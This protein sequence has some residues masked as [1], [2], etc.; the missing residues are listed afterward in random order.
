MNIK[1]RILLFVLLLELSGYSI[2]LLTNKQYSEEALLSVREKQI[3]AIFYGNLYRINSLTGLME[4]NVSDLATTGEQYYKLQK[5][6]INEDYT[7]SI[8]DYLVNN[9]SRFPESIGGGLWYE[10]YKFKSD[11]LYYGPYAY[12]EGQEVVLTWD[13][14]T[15]EYD[16]HNQDWYL[17]ALPKGYDRKQ[18]PEKE[19]CWT[20]PYYDDA[21]TLMLMM[22]V[23]AFMYD[24]SNEIIGL[25]TVD[26]A[27]TE[28]TSFVEDIKITP[29][30]HS[31]L[32]D[33]QSEKFLSQT[34]DKSKVMRT[35]SED[36]WSK[37]IINLSEKGMINSHHA[38]IGNVNYVIY[39]IQTDVGM[40]FGEI[41]PE[42]DLLHEIQGYAERNFTIGIIISATFI[43]LMLIA[44]NILFR[45]FNSVLNLIKNSIVL[46]KENN[47]VN[48][49]PMN[50]EGDNEFYP[51]ILALNNVYKEINDYT[52]QIEQQNKILHDNKSEIETLNRELE[53]KVFERTQKLEQ[54]SKDLESSLEKLQ[55]AS[56]KLVETEKMA[57]LGQLV[58]GLAH[59]INTPIG[60]CV[61]VSSTLKNNTQDFKESLESGELLKSKLIKYSDNIIESTDLIYSNLNR[62]ADLINSFKS[63]A[64]DQTAD[65]HR[66]FDLKLYLEDIF[67]TLHPRIKNTE[68][69]V[70]QKIPAGLVIDSRPGAVSQLITN[71]FMNSLSHGFE[72]R[73]KGVIEIQV[74][75][76]DDDYLEIIFSDDGNGMS[77]E[78][79]NSVFEPFYTTKRN[80]GG[81]GLGLYIVYNLVTQVLGGT[82]DIDSKQG[83]GTTFIIKIPKKIQDSN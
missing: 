16:Y 30:S 78:I 6:S 53:R 67:K 2:L 50:Y 17:S 83:E 47:S 14:N 45:P 28:M 72:G 66:E 43:I 10:P 36:A 3:E 61:T 81:S 57:A 55:E 79:I 63:V 9:F 76:L 59:E 18:R 19:F 11:Q 51:I 54:K 48:V 52:N 42:E 27:L 56:H 41:I 25:A 29:N 5:S 7:Q 65:E 32:I 12:W 38:V 58:A 33:K 24:D 21:G 44:L 71:L 69:S 15:P 8:K 80:A 82:I 75:D 68:Y 34:L 35:V 22:T 74:F 37:D 77:T 46:D 73:T 39:Y 60:T 62:A 31:F 49:T 64:V 1:T 23:D 13:L 4:R 20:E 40:I 70:V 26:W